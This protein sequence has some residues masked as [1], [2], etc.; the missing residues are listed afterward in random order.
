MLDDNDSV[1]FFFSIIIKID[2]NQSIIFLQF[3]IADKKNSFLVS[4]E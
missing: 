4:F 1:T 3:K 2:L